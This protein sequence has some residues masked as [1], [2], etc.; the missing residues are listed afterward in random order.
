ML[1]S[2][3]LQGP[4]IEAFLAHTLPALAAQ[5]LRVWVSVGGFSVG[6]YAGICERLEERAGRRGDRAQPLVPERRGGT[7]VVGGDRRRLPHPH[8][9]ALYAKLS[10]ATWDIAESA[11]G[12]RRSRSGRPLARQHD[13]RAG[14]RSA[15]APAEAR[16]RDRRV[17]GSGAQARRARVR[18]GVRA[19]GRCPHRLA[20]A[21]CAP[22][23][24]PSSSS[25]WVQALSRLAPYSS[26]IRLRRRRIRREL[27]EEA[28]AR[29]FADPLD[30]RGIAN[31]NQ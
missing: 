10:P 29:G 14:T 7:G 21:A 12:R 28:T 13:P 25:R 4:G 1:N 6:D 23:S 27:H 19:G 31:G 11:Q 17:L 2:I 24:T 20:W 5:G 26:P 30:A 18:L 15:H 16:P 3:G 8:V 22:A 9:E